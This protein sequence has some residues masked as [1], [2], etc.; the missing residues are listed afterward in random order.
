MSS[1]VKPTG[2]VTYDPFTVSEPF[3][4]EKRLPPDDEA[5]E[6]W[7]LGWKNEHLRNGSGIGWR[8]WI[9]M[10]YGDKWT[11]ESGELL[12]PYIPDAPRRMVG[13]D[14]IDN[15]VRRADTILCRIRADWFDQRQMASAAESQARVEN[16]R[17][18]EGDVILP[19]VKTIGG[20]RQVD[21]NPTFGRGGALDKALAA[22]IRQHNQ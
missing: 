7:Q 16:L 2:K 8:G 20:G 18:P 14:R 1:E 11:G 17:V 19:G 9:P 3:K 4:I 22:K 21:N 10:E 13:P 12:Q 15:L 6:G 5:P